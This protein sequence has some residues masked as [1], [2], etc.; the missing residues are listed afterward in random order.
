MGDS[1]SFS[2]RGPFASNQNPTTLSCSFQVVQ[3]S[4][5]KRI[6]NRKLP[7]EIK[8]GYVDTDEVTINLPSNY[9]IEAMGNPQ[10]L[11]TKFG[12]YSIQI[13]RINDNALLYKRSLHIKQGTYPASDYE[14]Y[15]KFRKKIHQLDHLK[16]AL[17]KKQQL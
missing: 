1:F 7:L 11:E 4:V 17:T 9:I 15:R 3:S 2:C 6:R 13:Q 12:N 5:P 14:A 8:Y 10:P 16:I